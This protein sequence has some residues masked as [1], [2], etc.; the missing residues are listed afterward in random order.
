MYLKGGEFKNQMVMVHET[1]CGLS[2]QLKKGGIDD[3]IEYGCQIESFDN[4]YA[5]WAWNFP[6]RKLQF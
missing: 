2:F 6:N 1:T 5:I 4:K 3:G